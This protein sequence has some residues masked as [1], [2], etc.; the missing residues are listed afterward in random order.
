MDE[1][2]LIQGMTDSQK[3]SFLNEMNRKRKDKTIAFVLTFF[4]GGIGAHHYYMG[5]IGVGV[6]YSLFFWTCIPA[7]ISI[8]ELFLIIGRVT[9]HNTYQAQEIASRVKAYV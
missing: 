1:L 7:L 5:K 9:R 6:L 4:L 8:V 2:A 3:I